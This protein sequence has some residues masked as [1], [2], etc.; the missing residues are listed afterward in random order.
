MIIIA[1]TFAFIAMA[2]LNNNHVNYTLLT[3]LIVAFLSTFIV[4]PRII[5]SYLFN[6][7]EEGY[8]VNIITYMQKYDKSVREKINEKEQERNK[9]E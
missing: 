7:K 4:L 9:K 6:N 8:L 3:E 2:S 1:S 5:A